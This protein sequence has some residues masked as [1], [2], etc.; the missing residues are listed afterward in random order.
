MVSQINP[1]ERAGGGGCLCSEAKIA[2]AKGPFIVFHGVETDNPFSPY[3]VLCADCACNAAHK[4]GL[5]AERAPL[6][7]GEAFDVTQ[8]VIDAAAAKAT[9]ERAVAKPGR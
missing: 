5:L 1:N 3:A 4:S 7:A 8:I 6:P 9:L 2:D